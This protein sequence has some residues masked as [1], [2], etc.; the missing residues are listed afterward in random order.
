MEHKGEVRWGDGV[1]V[2]WEILQFRC[3]ISW[4]YSTYIELYDDMWKFLARKPGVSIKYATWCK[5]Q[6][7]QETSDFFFDFFFLGGGGI[8]VIKGFIF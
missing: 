2:W 6:T 4:F 5:F 8:G 7:N 3:K 1:G